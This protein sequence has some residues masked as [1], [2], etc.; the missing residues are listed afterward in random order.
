MNCFYE[1]KSYCNI[2]FVRSTNC[3]CESKALF[4]IY[5]KKKARGFHRSKPK[6]TVSLI[7]NVSAF[8][9]SRVSIYRL[10]IDLLVIEATNTIQ[11]GEHYSR[12]RVF[13]SWIVA[14][15]DTLVSSSSFSAVLR[16][17]FIRAIVFNMGTC[18]TVGLLR[19]AKPVDL[20]IY[21]A[22]N[23]T[24][25]SAL[26]RSPPTLS[27]SLNDRTLRSPVYRYRSTLPII[28]YSKRRFQKLVRDSR[29]RRKKKNPAM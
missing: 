28:H 2:F 1:S 11:P 19:F 4:N 14:R 20:W 12:Y 13:P 10:D 7:D 17:T 3:F 8:T 6:L 26:N 18:T 29:A 15:A 23:W 9:L 5:E 24:A 22:I 21:R 16:S 27:V 25:L